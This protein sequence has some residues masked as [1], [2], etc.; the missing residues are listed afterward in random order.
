MSVAKPNQNPN[1][2]FCYTYWC[3]CDWYDECQ[4]NKRNKHADGDCCDGDHDSEEPDDPPHRMYPDRAVERTTGEERYEEMRSRKPKDPPYEVEVRFEDDDNQWGDDHITHRDEQNEE[5]EMDIRMEPMD[6]DEE[7]RAK[8]HG[9]PPQHLEQTH[10]HEYEGSTKLFEE[11]LERHNHRFAG[12][13]GE[14]ITVPGGHVH[15]I[16]T[17]TDYFGHFHVVCK[18]SGPAIPVGKPGKGVCKKHIHH[19]AG[20]TSIDEKHDHQFE[21]V[22]QI[23]EPLLPLEERGRD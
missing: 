19:V 9:Q 21:F 15:K 20:V 8:H 14:A 1:R 12:V 5:H 3:Y 22:T 17:R 11:G 18:L 4:M 13:T 23:N 6:D 2:K 16:W 7:E 10:V